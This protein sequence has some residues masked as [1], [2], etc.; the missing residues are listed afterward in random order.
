M[1]NLDRW[2]KQSPMSELASHADVVA[3]LPSDVGDLVRIVQGLLVHEAWLNAYGLDEGEYRHI[4]R[5]TLPIA[6][7]LDRVAVRESRQLRT[8]R[9]PHQREVGT[10]RDFALMLCSFL[11]GKQIPARVRCGFAA[12]FAAPWEDHWVC[13]YW[14]RR[15]G[16]WHLCDPQIDGVLKERCAIGFDPADV[17]RDRFLTAGEAWLACRAGRAD[18]RDFGHGDVTGTWFMK[19]NV[20]RD[21]CVLTHREISAWDDWRAAPPARR[22]VG[23]EELVLLDH[24]AASPDQPPVE[25]APDWLKPI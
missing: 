15:D 16:E 6:E 13:E 21:H 25:V 9:P 18:A 2:L 4:S 11:R 3:E 14:D 22:V 12:Y 1:P 5:A 10:C 8:A 24:L 17:P 7:R 20:V 19:I 23:D